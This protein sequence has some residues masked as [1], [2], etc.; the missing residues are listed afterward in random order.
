VNE[1]PETPARSQPATDPVIGVDEWVARAGERVAALPG[2]LGF[3]VRKFEVVP[4][5]VWLAGFAGLV[6]LVPVLASGPSN[7]YIVRVGTNTLVYALLALGLNVAVGFAGLLDLGYIAYFGVGAYGYAMLSSSKFGLHWEAW[8]SIPVVLAFATLLGFVLA[9]PSRRLIGDYFAIVTLFFGQIFYTL[10][11]QGY[12]VSLLGFTP[13]HD[14]TGGPNGIANVDSFHAFGAT[15]TSEQAYFYVALVAVVIV[16]AGLRLANRS[17]TGRAWRA[18]NDDALAA[19]VMSVPVNWLKVSAIGVGACI[20]ALAGT[21]NAALIQGALPDDYNTQVLIIIYAVLVLGGAGSL[22]GVVL[23]SIVVNGLDYFLRGG[24]SGSFQQ[25][26][27]IFYIAI[28]TVLVAKLRPWRLFAAVVAG[29]AAF[30]I[31]LHEIVGAVWSRGVHGFVALDPTTFGRGGWL[32]W[33]LRHWLTLP[34]GTYDVQNYTFFNYMLCLLIGLVLALTVVRGWKRYVLLVPTLW[35][36]SFVW[37]TRLV[38]DSPGPTRL[39]VF[40]ATLIVVM[41]VR[42]NGLLG[43]PRVEIV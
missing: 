26:R 21:I 15:A 6:A 42:P 1:T 27:W 38:E 23:G 34:A 8:Q 36:A 39:L 12:R 14:I 41:A 43:K 9:L 4:E 30:G 17:R 19:Q 31:V 32:G 5:V 10:A 35:L 16:F 13:S 22:L 7:Q 29:A 25:I 24:E 37:E 20:G 11:T 18:L 40:G 3:L 2:P 33:V 28:V